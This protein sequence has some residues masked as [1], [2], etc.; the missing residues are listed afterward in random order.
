[1]HILTP[2]LSAY[3]KYRNIIFTV[4]ASLICTVLITLPFFCH[5]SFSTHLAC[6]SVASFYSFCPFDNCSKTKTKAA[7][8]QGPQTMFPPNKGDGKNE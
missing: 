7:E 5:V 6:L 2:I 3:E 1:M 8:P 4:F